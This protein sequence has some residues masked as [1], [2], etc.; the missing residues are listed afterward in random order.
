MEN[1]TQKNDEPTPEAL[2]QGFQYVKECKAVLAEHYADENGP[3]T[4]DLLELCQMAVDDL[5]GIKTA[6]R[7]REENAPSQLV[8]DIRWAVQRVGRHSPAQ[9]VNFA[10]ADVDTFTCWECHEQFEGAPPNL[11]KYETG[12][13][14]VCSGCYVSQVRG[15]DVVR[16][17]NLQLPL[18][19]TAENG[20]KAALSGEF[21]ETIEVENPDFDDEKET[22]QEKVPVRWT[23]IKAIWRKA[24]EHF[25]CVQSVPAGPDAETPRERAMQLARMGIQGWNPRPAGNMLEMELHPPDAIKTA[26]IMAL[27]YC[28]PD[29]FDDAGL[30]AAQREALAATSA[31]LEARMQESGATDE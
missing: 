19:L 15:V 23:T 11:K 12:Y 16:N 24:V 1:D 30:T 3:S 28:F 2:I 10:M 17:I 4:K 26:G 9:A 21:F 18:R 7:A 29:L 31:A 13:E 5:G 14:A 25:S 22:V 20:A 8:D 6:W 27:A